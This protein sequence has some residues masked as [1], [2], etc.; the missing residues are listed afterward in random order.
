MS[1][2]STT[3][4]RSTTPTEMKQI[5]TPLIKA[6]PLCPQN[7]PPSS[8]RW[9]KIRL[10]LRSIGLGITSIIYG[11]EPRKSA[12]YRS[13]R[14]VLAASAIHVLP[15]TVSAFLLTF[16]IRGY[17][18][19]RE[20]EGSKGQDDLKLGALQIS[21]ELQELLITASLSAILLN[22]IRRH[23]VLKEGVPLG[24]LGSDKA[25]AQASFFW[26]VE[27]WGGV[28]SFR[29]Q[30]WRQKGPLIG[31][32]VLSGVLSLLAGP[33]TAVLMIP[34]MMDLPIGGSIFWL[35]GSQS[36]L[37][38]DV[39]EADLSLVNDCS[40]GQERL[41]RFRCPSA[42]F[43]P[44]YSYYS[45]WF[46]FAENVYKIQLEEST[47]TKSMYVAGAFGQQGD[48]W[49]YTTHAPSAVLQ[50]AA[51]SLYRDA[52]NSLRTTHPGVAPYPVNWMLAQTWRWKL[53]TQ[54]PAVR[55]ACLRH[56]PLTSID[57]GTL[58]NMKFPKLDTNSLYSEEQKPTI[59]VSIDVRSAVLTYLSS[60]ELSNNSA[61]FLEQRLP[62]PLVI[63]IESQAGSASSL[64]L[65]I[66][67][68]ETRSSR[69][70]AL[71]TCTVDA[72]W[73]KGRSV[74]ETNGGGLI[75]QVLSYDF[76]GSRSRIVVGAELEKDDSPSAWSDF[77]PKK[78]ELYKSIRIRS[79]WY[80]LLFPR[81]SD[82]SLPGGIVADTDTKTNTSFTPSLLERMVSLTQIPSINTTN[83]DTQLAYL[84]IH[85]STFFADGIS[86]TG[87]QR[88]LD[89]WRFFPAW[90]Y[91]YW[92]NGSETIFRSMVRNGDPVETFPRPSGLQGENATRMV[93]KAIFTG[94]AMKIQ[95]WFDWVS[96]VVLLLHA[97]VAIA[98][99]VWLLW[100]RQVGEG[101]DTIPE[102]VALSQQSAPADGGV[103]K[104]TCAGVRTMRTM[105]AVAVVRSQS[106]D[107]PVNFGKEELCLRFRHSW[108][109]KVP[110]SIPIEG[111][112][113][114][115][116][117]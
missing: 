25:F 66:I 109:T 35:N 76:Y 7:M 114:G 13:R 48:T 110:G 59:S 104:N 2:S 6:R 106:L 18:I 26:S 10:L 92:K 44:L 88:H 77:D 45:Q 86:H 22:V 117:E 54:V 82:S 100:E 20:L 9:Q 95:G 16:N 112:R 64:A 84:E 68:N 43:L 24:F 31:L 103:L 65:L 1:D 11:S 40:A 56:D 57:E 94:Y 99:T 21:A 12:F 101:W 72:R 32:L 107:E 30:S 19:G 96:A 98:S 51:V 23:L 60:N 111:E 108:E 62:S 29:N 47:L 50:S 61:L 70:L 113:Y 71:T 4:N 90:D 79:S 5:G 52:L 58:R 73:A 75:G 46:N 34:R 115:A 69:G 87:M 83:S 53:E 41:H 78:P 63:P 8:P 28:R 37:W 49:T 67:E 42:G 15:A 36:Q 91:G 14:A 116:L 27:F 85:L 3:I 81:V 39:L 74:V 33:A 93:V 17:F 97:I 89:T 102:L 38:P 105:E 55:V 80:D